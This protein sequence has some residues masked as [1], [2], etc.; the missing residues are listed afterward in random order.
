MGKIFGEPVAKPAIKAAF[1]FI[2]DWTFSEC[3]L[4]SNCAQVYSFREKESIYIKVYILS[5][6]IFD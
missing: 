3:S 5:V 4:S 1:C 6:M 2:P